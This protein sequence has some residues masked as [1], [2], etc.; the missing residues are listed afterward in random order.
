MPTPAPY[1]KGGIHTG[2][3]IGRFLITGELGAG[4][5]GVVYAA[6]DPK[7]D[8]KVA[9]KMLHEGI[10]TSHRA[11]LEREA[12]AM[13]KLT[14][15]NV[16]SVHEVGEFNNRLFVAME[17]VDGKTLRDWLSQDTPDK[18]QIMKVM[19]DAGR[20]LAAAHAAGMAHRDFKPD[21]ILVGSDGRARVSDFG[22][23]TPVG[24]DTI[25]EVKPKIG[26]ASQLS[27]SA[28]T[29]VGTV[30]GTPLYMAPEQHQGEAADH[31]ADQFSF[32]V[33]LWEALYE[34]TPYSANSYEA[35]VDNVVAE[36]IIAPSSAHK[37]PAWIRRILT[38]GLRVD[39]GDRYASMNELLVAL[40]HDPWKRRRRLAAGVTVI[41]L[42]GAAAI[43]LVLQS[44]AD[45]KQA[46]LCKGAD[47]LIQNVWT[48]QRRSEI[49]S[50]FEKS[51]QASAAANW[52]V[53]E[54]HLDA[55]AL[56]WASLRTQSCE[57][58][59]I[60]KDQSPKLLAFSMDCF[61][62]RLLHF[63]STL[64][65]FGTA[66]NQQVIENAVQTTN[67]LPSLQSCRSPSELERAT[68]LPN[69][70]VS[71][72]KILQLEETFAEVKRHDQRGE[73]R[74]A[75]AGTEMLADKAEALK[76]TPLAANILLARASLQ[77]T[78]GEI[79]A[80]EATF[81]A[82]ASA[83]ARAQDDVLVAR[84]WIRVLDLL[85]KQGRIDEALAI[86]TVASTSA[87]R[88]PD[89]FQ[90]QARL[91][92]TLGGI[93]LAKARY[94]KAAKAYETALAFQY[95]AGTDG[96]LQLA[97]AIANVGIAKW[98]QGDIQGAKRN[99]EKALAIMLNDYGPDHSQVAYARKSLGDAALALGD[100]EEAK[101]QYAEI[102]RI[103]RAS[104]GPNHPNLAYAYETLA[105]IAQRAG[106]MESAFAYVE[107]TIRVRKEFLA[108]TD[109]L[110]FQSV[111]V[112]IDFYLAE[113]SAESLALADAAIAENLQ[114]V[115]VL[116]EAGS[117]QRLLT[118]DGRAK[119]AERRE[120]WSAAMADRMAT[121]ELRRSTLG[122]GHLDTAFTY[123]KIAGDLLQ[124]GDLKKSE[125][126]LS[127]AQAIYDQTPG[128]GDRDGVGMRR[129]RAI[130]K[131]QQHKNAEAMAL[132]QEALAK[133]QS[134]AS[135]A[136]LVP[137]VKFD[138]AKV[139][140]SM[141]QRKQALA[142]THDILG[143]LDQ[144]SLTTLGA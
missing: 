92:N 115:E 121:L 45:R 25:D 43:V 143:A 103:W 51:G 73:Y 137:I 111:R 106:D 86:E 131:I 134:G 26:A 66:P 105:Q 23:V 79:E 67:D 120:Q 6:Y 47:A 100:D 4:G 36:R 53:S 90:V 128:P 42:T 50:A 39:P 83:A 127:L 58:T 116:G 32:C 91:Q 97:P 74:E 59:R 46:G 123:A 130:V 142:D 48:E 9:I 69:D 24:A 16:V 37:G 81:R 84:V 136:Y 13:A 87:E 95:K 29:Q 107:K 71:R 38:R 88:V 31:R 70:P 140:Y 52:G 138:L 114:R 109:P 68:P 135:T 56:E 14:H 12:R 7:L 5:M 93:Y 82:A 126:F 15:P 141:G 102:L 108:P 96:N 63:R 11:R 34:K 44:R 94:D 85:A 60:T 22:L 75:L 21:N 61:D 78:L 35:L 119:L 112:A 28:L 77:Q 110:I 30:M 133:A 65:L 122:E 80:A 64:T 76:Y 89:A 57:A 101:V 139:R 1:V 118:L 99:Y 19:I 144:S 18:K 98:Y 54:K 72:R 132:F 125:E 40:E 10:R 33:T 20:G 41:G 113:G 49:R 3:Q 117:Q 124:L 2:T 8:R 55:Y 17:Y 27:V 129:S 62:R 104:L